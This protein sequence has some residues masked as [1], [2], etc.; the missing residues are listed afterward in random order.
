MSSI[1]QQES[2]SISRNVRLG[3]QYLMQQGK[4]RLNDR[5]F[6]GLAKGE[7]KYSLLI[8]PQE[9]D[10]VR[11][12][13]REFLEGF[14]PGRIAA[15]SMISRFELLSPV[16]CSV[17]RIKNCW[18]SVMAYTWVSVSMPEHPQMKALLI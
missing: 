8:I 5:Q 2:D 7:D 1:A 9:A 12:I 10:L 11:R 15:R 16:R 4:G 13:Y 14:S 17:I 18:T 3:I 6:L